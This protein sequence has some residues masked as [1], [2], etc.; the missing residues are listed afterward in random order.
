MISVT[1]HG[2]TFS[3]KYS[4]NLITALAVSQKL[5]PPV[6]YCIRKDHKISIVIQSGKVKV[7]MLKLRAF[8]KEKLDLY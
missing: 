7:Y 6:S 5:D 4:Q 1:F 8:L 3:E 2:S